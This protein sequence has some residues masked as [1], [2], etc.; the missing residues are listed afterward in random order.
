MT[1]S[2]AKLLVISNGGVQEVQ[3]G[4]ELTIGRAYSNLLR[5]DGDEVSRV[6][7]IIYRRENDYLLRDLDSK[8]GV[9]LNGQRVSVS[10][11]VPG[12]EIQIGNYLLVFD[13]P[14]S[15]DV[16]EFMRRHKI[17]G[18][19]PAVNLSPQPTPIAASES[20][21]REDTGDRFDTSLHFV[22]P[23][24]EQVFFPL[25]EI[26]SQT[27]T[28]ALPMSANFQIDL[29]RALRCL[30]PGEDDSPPHGTILYKQVLRGAL[31]ATKADRGVLVLR[32]PEA[33]ALTLGAILPRD[34]D[35]SV[36]RVVLRAVLREHCAVLC[37]DAL[38]D[39]RF[40]KTE[41]VHKE[42]ITSLIAHPLMRGKIAVGLLYLDTQERPHMF[43]RDHLQILHFLA[44]IAVLAMDHR[45]M[46][47]PKG[48]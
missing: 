29:V 16:A 17:E 47:L 32:E 45:H 21:S 37:N 14:P 40:Q 5:L 33:E 10:L 30:T 7:A 18:S 39:P 48:K 27:Q 1:R 38:N 24:L 44:R 41:T 3:L 31:A 34:R 19:A 42:K 12:D 46:D 28:D 15:F 4:Q 43:R 13:P 22:P 35:V 8:N 2:M 11:V 25:S 23:E 20:P 26:E 6:H 36:N 9:W